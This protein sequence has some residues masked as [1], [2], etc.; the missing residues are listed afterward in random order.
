MSEQLEPVVETLEV[1]TAILTYTI[2]GTEVNV[3]V[4]KPPEKLYYRVDKLTN[5]FLHATQTQGEFAADPADMYLYGEYDTSGSNEML[6]YYLLGKFIF[7]I[8]SEEF[9]EL[10]TRVIVSVTIDDQGTLSLVTSLRPKALT[11]PEPDEYI[12][13]DPALAD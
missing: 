9:A 2:D 8:E 13:P 11:P 6:T 5:R 1:E 4:T 7:N 12:P 3:T 10:V